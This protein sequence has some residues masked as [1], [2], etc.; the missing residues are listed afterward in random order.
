M[1]ELSG[2]SLRDELHPDGDIEISVTGLRPGEKLF[3]ELLIGNNPMPTKH[4]S[5]IKAHEQFLPWEKLDG[6]L[7]T[8]SIAITQNDVPLI[9]SILRSLVTDYHPQGEVVDW[10]HL[11]KDKSTQII[12]KNNY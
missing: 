5:I 4:P 3:E 2:R 6:N 10:V 7:K 8:L 9:I 12:P 1:I 11:E